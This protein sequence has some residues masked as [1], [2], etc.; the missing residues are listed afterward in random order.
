MTAPASDKEILLV[1][2]GVTV[3]FLLF[4]IG[5][6][7]FVVIYYQKQR[8]HQREKKEAEIRHREDLALTQQEIRSELLRNVSDEI[9]DNLG[10]VASL[11]KI[12]TGLLE[13][14]EE[15]QETHTELKKLVNRMIFDLKSL[16][17]NV[18]PDYILQT[19]LVAAIETDIKRLQHTGMIEVHYEKTTCELPLDAGHQLIIYRLFQE[20]L[21]NVIKHAEASE[22]HIHIFSDEHCIRFAMQ[23]NGKGFSL[24][25]LSLDN[26]ADKSGIANLYRRTKTI[27]GKMDI[28]SDGSG[29]H[30]QFF[31]DYN[32]MYDGK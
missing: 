28:Q 2:A 23:D 17:L 12:Y 25:D 31:L 21:H 30:I 11:V 18:H 26:A 5:L 29:T 27:G 32:T 3:F 22:V 6:I 15:H 13:V 24:N 8:H 7:M 1:I 16:S 20:S 19:G 9:H 4:S 10:Q 14:P